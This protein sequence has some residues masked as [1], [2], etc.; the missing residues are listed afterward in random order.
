MKSGWR[1]WDPYFGVVVVVLCCGVSVR[2]SAAGDNSPRVRVVRTTAPPVIDG[3]LTEAV[4]AGAAEISA[5]TQAEPDEGAPPSEQTSVFLL[6]DSEFLYIGVRAFDS[7]PEKIV[8]KARQRDSDLDGDDSLALALDTFH[9]R[10]HGYYFQVNPLGTQRDGLI[11]PDTNTEATK[12]EY[13]ADWD[14]IWYAAAS[15]NE[16]CWTAEVAIP[17]KT[18]RFDPRSP[19]W[20]FNIQ[21]TIARKSEIIR[22]AAARRNKEVITMGDAGRLDNLVG[23]DKGVGLD[24]IPSATLKMGR[25][26]RRAKTSVR[27]D[28]SL[29]LFYRV[30]PAV[31]LALTLNTDFAETEVDERRVN[32]TRFPLFFEEKRDFFLQD[33]NYFRFGGIQ[34]SPLP[35]FSRR[36]GLSTE[37][38]PVDLLGGMKVTGRVGRVNFGLLDTYMDE[39]QELPAKNLAVGRAT[40]D[41]LAESAIGVIFTS[42]DPTQRGDA[43]L[44]GTDF[45]YKTSDLQGTGQTLEANGYLMRSTRN[46]AAGNAW[47]VRLLYPNFTWNAALLFDQIDGDFSPALGFLEQAGIRSYEGWIGHTWRPPG[48]DAVY[49]EAFG[50]LRTRLDNVVIDRELWLPSFSIETKARDRFFLGV[51]L[52][53]EQFFEPFTLVE[54]LV[55]PARDY[56]YLRYVLGGETAETRP[57][58]GAAEVVFGG[59]LHGTRTDMTGDV[60]WRPNS[61]ADGTVSYERHA[62]ALP[63]EAFTVHI[64]RITVSFALT[65]ALIWRLTG[66]Y[67]NVSHEFGLNSR[68]WWLASPG[69]DVFLVF[70]YQ[71]EAT[72]GGWRPQRLELTS[73]VVW[74]FRF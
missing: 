34:T 54:N 31:T 72:Q 11:A 5:F 28:P 35:F 3:H 61:W 51:V 67:D 44:V 27:F 30:T 74:T 2:P 33:A 22:W 41:V 14:G 18:V 25:D 12:L 62:I 53:R 59:Y 48:L 49:L 36:I 6:Y 38:L 40:V 19:T 26:N 65:P 21:R 70:N 17:T 55:V 45:Q 15:I 68:L 29:D 39:A 64:A 58:A 42:G 20:G 23:L 50:K 46:G 9:D 57:L 73:K 71:A 56:H 1:A 52:G 7:A 4:W 69:N 37:G 8:A 66:Q 24:L 47:G 16:T 60:T 10:R 63:P 13:Q 32:L 43:H